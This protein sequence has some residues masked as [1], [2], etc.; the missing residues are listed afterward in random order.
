MNRWL[1]AVLVTLAL[2][3]LVSPGIVGRLAEKSVEENLNLAAG[4]NDDIV[5]TTESFDRGW[6]TSEGR[7]RIELRQ[8]ALHSVF[9]GED[10]ASNAIPALVVDTHVDHGLLPLSSL[11]RD[12]SSLK[13]GL[14]ST[15][16]TIAL[17]PGDGQII[18]LPGKIYSEV[19]LSG[20]TASRFVLEAGSRNID[21]GSVEWQ[22]ADVTVKTNPA[23]GAVSVDG[24]VQPWATMYAGGGEDRSRISFGDIRIHGQQEKSPHGLAVGSIKLEV[25]PASV[26]GGSGPATGF[27]S[28]SIDAHSEIIDDRLSSVAKLAITGIKDSDLDG[29]DIALD[30]TLNGLDAQAAGRIARALQGIQGSPDPQGAL[31]GIYP[32][33]ESDVQTLLVSGMEIRLDRLDVALPDGELTTKF[34]FSLPPTAPQSDFSWP[35]LL[36]ALDASADIRLPVALFE[37]AQEMSPD[38]GMLVAMGVLK[39]SDDYY[40]MQAEYAKGLVTVNGAPLPIPLQALQQ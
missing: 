18:K 12:V 23:S 32:L 11:A 9:V 6:F 31:S 30:V 8:G 25:G 19:G 37:M 40:E 33:I 15:V 29:V 16:S 34:R 24:S 13:P 7:H 1:V 36:L 26:A 5:V 20:A 28:L 27:Q 17:D 21:G 3:V 22:G 4:E 10:D 14:A 38:A 35:A 39:K 2:I